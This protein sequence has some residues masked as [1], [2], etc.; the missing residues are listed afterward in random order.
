MTA[1]QIEHARDGGFIDGRAGAC[2]A[3]LNE[4]REVTTG[5]RPEQKRLG[6][7]KHRLIL[8]GEDARHQVTSAAQEHV[9]DLRLVLKDR[10]HRRWEVWVEVDDRLELVENESDSD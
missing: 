3:V 5:K 7:A 4:A 2:E 9:G 8:V 1:G 6:E 10:P